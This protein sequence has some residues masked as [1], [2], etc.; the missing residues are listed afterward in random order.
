MLPEGLRRELTKQFICEHRVSLLKLGLTNIPNTDYADELR[1]LKQ[2][3]IQSFGFEWLEYARFGWDEPVYNIQRE[4][5][6]F[7]YKSL[8]EPSDISGKLI[9]D[10]GCGNGRYTYWAA[11]YGGQVIGVD[12]GDGVESA[13]QN[14]ETLPNVQVVQGDIF[15]LPFE[16]ECF[17]VIFSIGVLMHTGDAKKATGSLISRLKPG[18]SLT[19]HVYGKGNPIY[20]F[21]DYALRNRTTRMSIA[22]LKE[23]TRKVYRL[24]RGLE[25]LRVATLISPRFVRLDP[26]PHCIF[27]WYAAPVATHHAYGEVK[28]WFRELDL[29]II[30]TNEHFLSGSLIRHALRSLFGGIASTVTVRG[31]STIKQR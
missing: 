3:T 15:N 21:V 8:L 11:K 16:K 26:H 14:T 30:K 6:I 13:S 2:R 25:R 22:Q 5:S 20:E 12:L 23:F 7:R 19:V 29:E 1:E 9:L 28:G 24:R 17:D 31:I 4:E 18:G 27:D 10:A